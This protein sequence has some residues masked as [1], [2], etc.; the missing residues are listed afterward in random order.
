[1]ATT[2]TTGGGAQRVYLDIPAAVL[3]YGRPKRGKT[4]DTLYAFP[5]GI[6]F[7]DPGN[8]KSAVS[9]VGVEPAEVIFTGPGSAAEDLDAVAAYLDKYLVGKSHPFDAVVLDDAS[10]QA[11]RTKERLA[12]RFDGWTLWGKVEASL[13]GVIDRGRQVKCHTVFNMHELPKDVEDSVPIGCPML[14][15]RR[16]SANTPAYMDLV[17]RAYNEPMRSP[18]PLAYY[19]A[20]QDDWCV[21]DRHHICWE[22]TPMNLGEILR[23]AKYKLNRP[24]GLEWQE[25]LIEGGAVT[26]MAGKDKTAVVKRIWDVCTERGCQPQHAAWAVRDACDRAEIRTHQADWFRKA[27]LEGGASPF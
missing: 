22:N 4:T 27:Y 20:I 10:V 6:F 26:I 21:G 13:Q 5:R 23:A 2:P 12:R 17:I 11:A 1:M 3:I 24:K 14:P 9:V 8:F 7:G 25:A 16:I 19:N 18:V 15:S